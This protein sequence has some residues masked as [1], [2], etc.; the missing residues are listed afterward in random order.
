MAGFSRL[1]TTIK[2]EGNSM[3]KVS[4]ILFVLALAGAAYAQQVETA[5]GNGKAHPSSNQ[6][7][8]GG[9]VDFVSVSS[10]ETTLS[11]LATMVATAIASGTSTISSNARLMTIT[12]RPFFPQSRC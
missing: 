4:V 1:T 11:A 5:L 10:L 6:A 12:A 7:G 2:G 3:K 8:G 9:S